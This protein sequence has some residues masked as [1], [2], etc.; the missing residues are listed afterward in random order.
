MSMEPIAHAGGQ[1][2]RFA[3]ETAFA[4]FSHVSE[5]PSNFAHNLTS[6]YE[7]SQYKFKN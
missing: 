1:I 6:P 5:S 4:H 7:A 2:Y 3:L